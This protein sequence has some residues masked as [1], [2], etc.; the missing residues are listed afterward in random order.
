MT[1]GQHRI[2]YSVLSGALAA[3]I[4]LSA[5]QGVKMRRVSRTLEDTYQSALAEAIDHMSGLNVKL[6]KLLLTPDGRVLLSQISREAGEAQS[7]LSLLPLSHQALG[8]AIRFCAQTGDYAQTLIRQEAMSEADQRQVEKLAAQ[9]ALLWSQLELSRQQMARE[10]LNFQDEN[11]AF[12]L[13]AQGDARPVEQ[14]Y[15]ED[16]AYPTLI[17]DGAFSDA[18]H[19]GVPKGLPSGEVSQEEANTIARAFVG[20]GVQE[21]QAAPSAGGA[22][23]AWGVSVQTADVLLNVEVTKQG[24]KVLWM[25]PEHGDFAPLMTLDECRDKA[26]EFLNSRGFE[27]MEAN[28]YQVYEGIVTI[29]FT[30]VQDGVVLYPDQVKVQCRLDTGAVVGLEANNYWMNHV[31]RVDLTPRLTEK[32]AR[33][34][35]SEKLNIT[36]TRLCLIPYLGNE[37]LC[38]EL[39]GTYEEGEYRAYIDADTGEQR[40]LLKIVPTDNGILTV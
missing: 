4:L 9:A 7:C 27:N 40:E 23:P 1:K 26:A 16:M 39:A 5:W 2:F 38:W 15:D 14:L 33:E 34:R 8:E 30:S 19:R 18:Q 37:K 31:K 3:A 25:V 35:A 13:N 36:Q 21:V 32:E 11:S 12:Y 17:Y 29:N 28:H 20:Q 10:N 22:I 24:G 6:E